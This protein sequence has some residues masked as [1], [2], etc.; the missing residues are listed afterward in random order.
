MNA[1]KLCAY[2]G[3]KGDIVSLKQIGNGHINGTYSLVTDEDGRPAVYVVQRINHYVFKD[4]VRLMENVKN[5]T[6]HMRAKYIKMGI[7]PQRLVLEFMAS[8]DGSCCFIDN[9]EYFRCYR[10]IDGSTV[11]SSSRSSWGI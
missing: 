2:F 10:F 8:M 1:S 9:G 5:V 11:V 7:N 3:I 6:D 4:P